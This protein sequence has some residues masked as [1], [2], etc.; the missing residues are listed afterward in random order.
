M[1]R[2]LAVIAAAIVCVGVSSADDK[3][4]DPAKLVGKWEVTKSDSEAELKGAI[5][6]FMKDGKVTVTMEA[7]GKKLVFTGTYA[8]DADKL[9]VTLKNP[10]DGKESS[11]ADTIKALTDDKIVLVDKDKKETELTKKK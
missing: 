2:F 9:K 7:A 5:V 4:I 3:K 11:D 8:V 10:E 1:K 6:D